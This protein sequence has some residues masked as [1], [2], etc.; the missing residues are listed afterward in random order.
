MQDPSTMAKLFLDFQ[1]AYGHFWTGIDS[2]EELNKYK[3][4]FWSEAL[5]DIDSKILL[6]AG[7]K[8]AQKNKFIPSPS[9][10]REYCDEVLIENFIEANNIPSMQD[11]K[12]LFN[13]R[14][15]DLWIGFEGLHEQL[16]LNLKDKTG[17]PN[18]KE[19]PLEVLNK[20]FP[21]AYREVILLFVSL[22]SQSEHDN[23]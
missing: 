4:S 11:C 6:A 3:K 5:G 23:V 2:T 17:F 15:N 7:F 10:L 13:Y 16:R 19:I 9:G 14:H 20:I 22:P 21:T 1:V 8:W 12:R 18:V